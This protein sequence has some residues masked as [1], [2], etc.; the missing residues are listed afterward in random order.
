LKRA[1]AVVEAE[2]HRDQS[3]RRVADDSAASDDDEDIEA[4][5]E[6]GRSVV[7]RLLG[8]QVIHDGPEPG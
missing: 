4:A 6:V 3:G 2:G 1:L 8:G 5:G 7:E